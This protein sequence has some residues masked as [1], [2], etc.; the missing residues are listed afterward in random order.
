MDPPCPGRSPSRTWH[1]GRP[2]QRALGVRLEL[3]GNGVL[4]SLI[5][6]NLHNLRGLRG[7]RGQRGFSASPSLFRPLAEHLFLA[8]QATVPETRGSVPC[9]PTFGGCHFLSTGGDARPARNGHLCSRGLSSGAWAGPGREG[10]SGLLKNP[11]SAQRCRGP[12]GARPALP[13][14]P[15]GRRHRLSPPPAPAPLHCGPGPGAARSGRRARRGPAQRLPVF[16]GRAGQEWCLRRLRV[17][18]IKK[19]AAIL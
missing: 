17:E 3:P 1:H 14:R 19:T 13:S 7:L 9:V 6:I 12:S 18:K 11:P 10:P 16:K 5:L 4:F 8:L 15:R 2:W